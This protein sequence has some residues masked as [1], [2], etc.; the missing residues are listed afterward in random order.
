[1]MRDKKELWPIEK[2]HTNSILK[3]FDDVADLPITV[4]KETNQIASIW[5]V[6]SFWERLK[7]LWSGEVTFLCWGN[8]HP[9]INISLTDTIMRAK[10][11]KK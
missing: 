6:D 2:W 9:P 11:V 4:F 3:G 1:M 10:D 8:T 7:F 5:K